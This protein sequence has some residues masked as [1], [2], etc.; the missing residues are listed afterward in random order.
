MVG[1]GG[2]GIQD[3][4]LVHDDLRLHDPVGDEGAGAMVGVRPEVTTPHRRSFNRR[5]TAAASGYTGVMSTGVVYESPTF[6][7]VEEMETVTA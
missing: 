2:C 5:S 3:N 1:I 4:Q 7:V 6:E